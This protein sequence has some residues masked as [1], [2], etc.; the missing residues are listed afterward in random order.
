MGGVFTKQNSDCA[1][2]TNP[3]PTTNTHPSSTATTASTTPTPAAAQNQSLFK[4]LLTTNKSEHYDEEGRGDEGRRE[5]TI[6][7]NNN[8]TNSNRLGKARDLVQNIGSKAANA[9]RSTMGAAK[10][11]GGIL[12]NNAKT[13]AAFTGSFGASVLGSALRG[14][15]TR[16]G[17]EK[18]NTPT[19][20]KNKKKK[21][22]AHKK[23]TSK[24]GCMRK[25]KRE[26]G[27]DELMNE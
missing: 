5:N 17:K 13:A 27:R 8:L 24:A 2:E 11:A 22:K 16:R 3:P 14:G 25:R 23:G 21:K 18:E 15:G 10:D 9:T 7:T 26:G 12:L 4:G 6:S 1:C 19:R 20:K